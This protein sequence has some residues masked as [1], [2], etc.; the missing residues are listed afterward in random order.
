MLKLMVAKAYLWWQHRLHRGWAAKALLHL[1]ELIL[2][3]EHTTVQGLHI[4]AVIHLWSARKST[5]VDGRHYVV[6]ARTCRSI[7]ALRR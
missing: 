6:K 5:H 2:V 4:A 3:G 1:R 7:E